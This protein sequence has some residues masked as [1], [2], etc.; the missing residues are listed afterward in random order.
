MEK[1]GDQIKALA[2]E[3]TKFRSVLGTTGEIAIAEMIYAHLQQLEYF[4]QHPDNLRLQPVPGHPH[5]RKYVLAIVES[6]PRCANTV[7]CLGHIDTVGVD[8][9]ADLK[10]YATNPS[11]LKTR[12][13]SIKFSEPTVSELASDKWL[14][15]RGILDMKTGIAAEMVMI[16]KF[17][18]DPTAFAGNLVLAAVPDEEGDSAG[19]LAAVQ[20]LAT[21][22]DARGWNFAAAVD[23]DYTTARYPDDDHKYV[24]VGTVGKLLPSFYVYG[25]ETHVGEAFNGIDANLLAA[26]ILR[27]I[28]LNTELCDSAD[29]EVTLPPISLHQRDLKAEYSVQ[30]ANTVTMYF[31]YATHASQPD[32]VL[33]K[34]KAKA[35]QAFANVIEYLNDQ[36]ARYCAISNLPAKRL[37]WQMQV[38]TYEEL[39]RNVKAEMGD[40][41]DQIVA[42]L[43][44]ALKAQ[45]VD[46]RDF[47]QAIV[48]K[49]HQCY[50]NQDSKIIV[51]FSPP[52]Y[53]HIYV[54]GTD[55]KEQ[56]LLAAVNAAIDAARQE[57][58]YNI[59]VKKF[60]PYISDLSCCSISQDPAIIGKLT[61]NMPAWQIKYK[62]PISAIQRI[63]MPV[64]NIGPFGKD[65]HKLSERLCIDYSFDAMPVIL[66]RTLQN[67]L[68]K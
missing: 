54:Q 21:I 40:K 32:A 6:E 65:A 34:C 55:G 18:A 26:E 60:Y 29:G 66:E 47:S 17:A 23:T 11:E 7:L 63:S 42:D 37:P 52:Y 48:H 38:L 64:V 35:E 43:A 39:Y 27:Q 25:E 9:Y 10:Q 1:L 13:Q 24:Y 33:A 58:D 22:A 56:N 41:L 14:V 59:V 28:D 51:Y 50:S 12:L 15:G 44:R 3:L 61:G 62:L 49:V 46:D 31:N 4:R 45:G 16:E 57:F 19:M 67:L 30:T 53:P 36:Y 68:G 5:G 2:I 20:E 8:D